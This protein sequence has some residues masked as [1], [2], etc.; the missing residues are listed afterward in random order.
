MHTKSNLKSN[1]NPPTI[2][3]H[4]I[5]LIPG[6]IYLLQKYFYSATNK[7][8]LRRINHPTSNFFA[9]KSISLY[10]Q[11]CKPVKVKYFFSCIV[12][13][14]FLCLVSFFL[15][16]INPWGSGIQYSEC[17][18]ISTGWDLVNMNLQNTIKFKIVIS[19]WWTLK[20]KTFI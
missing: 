8:F 13:H 6:N 1:L 4:S 20:M 2:L 5:L 17:S 12:L 15:K 10:V 19:H 18:N 3:S 7:D 14:N 9:I 16:C 11:S